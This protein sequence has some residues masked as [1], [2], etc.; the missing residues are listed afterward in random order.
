[1]G[2][3]VGHHYAVIAHVFVHPHSADH[4]HVAIIGESLLELQE[5]PFDVAEVVRP[6]YLACPLRHCRTSVAAMEREP[7]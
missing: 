5:V 4:I 7:D 1:V 6:N 3:V 2:S